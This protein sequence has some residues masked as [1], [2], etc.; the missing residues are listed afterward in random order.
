MTTF[1]PFRNG[2]PPALVDLWN[3]ALPDRGVVRPLTAHEF[4]TLV[5]SKLPFDRLGLT[6]ADRDG[7]VVGFAHA[8]FGPEQPLGP[9][10]QLDTAMGTVAMLVTEPGRDD[11]D[12]EMGL[13]LASERYLRS[14]GAQV[15]YAGGQTPMDPFYAG[16]YGGS[17]FSGVLDSHEAFRRAAMR[18]GYAPAA[19]T[20]ILEADLARPDPRD[21]KALLLRRQLRLEIADDARTPGWWDALAIGLFRPSRFVLVDKI[22]SLPVAQAWTWEIA[23]GFGVGDS[24]CRTGLIDVEVHPD[25]R[26][27]GYGRHLV[28]EILR[29]V[30]D[31]NI[32]VL[33][34]QTSSEN[35]PALVL[36]KSLGFEPVDTA[37]LYRLPADVAS[38]SLSDRA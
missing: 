37:T 34:V 5:M 17:E 20:T 7:V 36:Y 29:R 16:V 19:A 2:D 18:A 14:R 12:L 27:K 11:P 15:F 4:D 10:H 25:H 22:L 3:R 23:G 38:R 9:S 35:L 6:V 26:R 1:R 8:G 30:R 32:D 33:T 28:G 31:Q 24:L 21:P 13:F